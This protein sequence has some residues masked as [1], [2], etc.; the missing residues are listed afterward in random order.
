MKSKIIN[1][2]ERLKDPEDRMLETLFAAGPIADD[3]FSEQIVGRIR[4]RLWM[5]RLCV[6]AA[7]LLGGAVAL[8]PSLALAGMLVQLLA[9]VSG[10]LL[11]VTADAVPSVTMLAGGG[12]LFF[13]V[14]VALRLLED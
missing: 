8:K 5:R 12:M 10:R 9:D 1:M 14:F 4:R 11:G 6:M 3:G 7:L 2:A 13:L